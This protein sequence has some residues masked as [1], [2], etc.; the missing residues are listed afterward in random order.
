M[1]RRTSK[2]ILPAITGRGFTAA[3]L[4][5]TYL[6]V[7]TNTSTANPAHPHIRRFCLEFS[8]ISPFIAAEILQGNDAQTDR[9]Q[10]AYDG[11]GELF[12]R[13]GLAQDAEKHRQALNSWDD[14]E[15]GYP[16]LKLAHVLDMAEAV[17]AL[18]ANEETVAERYLHDDGFRGHLK[19]LME[20]AAPIKKRIG[21]DR[22]WRK[23]VALIGALYKSGLFDRG[24]QEAR[25]K[26]KITSLNYSEMIK[27]GR[28]L[29]F[30]MQGLDSPQHRNLAISDLLRGVMEAQDELYAKAPAENKPKTVVII[31]EAHEFVSAERIKQMPM[32]FGQIARIARRGRKRWLGLV[33]ATQFPQHLPGE[34]FALCNNRILMRL[35]DEPTINRLKHSVG[36]VTENL[37]G[38]LK[39]L[40]TGHAIVS[41]QGLDPA[42]IVALDPGRCKLRMVD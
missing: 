31:E 24:G 36:G 2:K 15:T 33:F 7:P 42:M 20:Q 9:F 30:D 18:V 35:G 28:I 12:T 4:Q 25:D 41:A 10:A 19:P 27:P 22:S 14:Q 39:N 3:G 16:N 6:L 5:E 23:T 40:P 32:V 34:L 21:H 13:L 17:S 11:A 38:R 37:W 29:V 26:R 1:S 8:N